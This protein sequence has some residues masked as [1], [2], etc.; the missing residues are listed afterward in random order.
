MPEFWIEENIRPN[1]PNDMDRVLFYHIKR[2]VNYLKQQG[3]L[4]TWHFLRESTN[5]RG[6]GTQP[7]HIPHI[8]FRVKTREA[9]LQNV[10]NYIKNELDKLQQIGEIADHYRGNHGT[11]NRD[12]CGESNNFDESGVTNPE[13][14]IVAQK[15][16]EAGSELELI[17]LK[18]RFQGIQLGPRFNLLNFLHFT[19][20]QCGRDHDITRNGRFMIFQL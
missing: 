19:G 1:T 11:P 18:S 15:W 4:I 6:C 9:N 20:N 8:R 14:W 3:W 16:L 2:I 13:G 12:Y 17:L 7:P 5:W 10:R